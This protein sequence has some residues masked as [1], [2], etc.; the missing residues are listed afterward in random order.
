MVNKSALGIFFRIP[1]YGK[2]KKRLASEIGE[3][4]ALNAYKSMLNVTIDN[5]S[6]LQDTDI[7]GFYEGE[8]TSLHITLF[9]FRK[10]GQKGFPE[11][12]SLIPQKGKNLGGRMFNAIKCLFEKGY[13]RVLLIGI[14]SPDLPLS[15]IVDA[16][17]KL[18]Y[19]ELVIGPSEDGGYY[20]IGLTKPIK[21]LFTN[22]HWG[23][24]NV[25]NETISRAEYSRISYFLLP[26]WYDIDNLNNLLRWKRK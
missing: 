1:I 4:A 11:K 13:E 2:V 21:N 14:D 9:S 22:I 18:E 6:R 5:V 8:K 16:F 19:Y 20:L 15:S 12:I 17:K 3:E 24:S 25:L 7:F 23:S 10:G 26:R